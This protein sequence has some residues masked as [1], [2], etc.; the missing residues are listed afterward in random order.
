MRCDVG[1]LTGKEILN[2]PFEDKWQVE[3]GLI[4]LATA[5]ASSVFVMMNRNWQRQ[6]LQ[7]FAPDDDIPPS[8]ALLDY[9]PAYIIAADGYF[10]L[11]TP[12]HADYPARLEQLTL[13]K[14]GFTLRDITRNQTQRFYFHEIQWASAVAFAD[15]D[16]ATIYLHFD[17]HHIWRI[18][19]LKLPAR[20]MQLFI[21][22]LRR[23]L[24]YG[25]HSFDQPYT[26]IGPLAARIAGQNW[27]GDVMLGTQVSL[28]LLPHLLVVLVGDVVYAKLAT[29]S[30]RRVISLERDT[31]GLGRLVQRRRNG[32][33]VRLH[34]MTETVAFALSHYHELAD[35]IAFVARCPVEHIKQRDKRDKV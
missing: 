3:I 25:R 16:T 23:V 4:A 30:I 34:S 29:G 19:M 1:Y 27:Q 14:D 5:V 6:R 9:P 24:P 28:Y 31:V 21:R 10:Q 32:G 18:L 20:E 2:R 17:S 26:P 11:G 15:D 12:H 22:M 8:T 35:E 7:Q 33:L 13:T